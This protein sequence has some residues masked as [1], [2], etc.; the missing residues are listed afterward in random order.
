MNTSAGNFSI[1]V[2]GRKIAF[3]TLVQYAG[4]GL[5]LVLAAISLK[6]ISNFLSQGGYGVYASIT[7]YALFFSTIANLG[8]FGNVVRMMAEKPTDSGIFMN[9]LVL[10]MITALIFFVSGVAISFLNGMNS[11]FIIGTTL[12]LGSLFFDYVTSVCDGMLQANYEMGR[13]NF[14]LVLGKI[15]NTSAIFL[16]TRTF[17]GDID[18]VGMFCVLGIIMSGSFVTAAL[19]LFFVSR[20]IHLKF[21][22]NKTLMIKIL[23]VSVP[24]GVINIVNN[25]YFR[26]L[27]D[28]LSRGALDDVHFA[29]FNIYFRIAQVLSLASTFLMFSALPALTD[30]IKEGHKEKAQKLYRIMRKILL[31]GGAVLVILGS[32]L[33]PTVI[34]LLT[35]QKCNHPEH[36]PP[37]HLHIPFGKKYVHICPGCERRIELIPPN[38]S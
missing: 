2:L 27:P 32:L 17:H 16:L 5:Q 36:E 26:F 1:G 18:I 37:T 19:S 9:S 29:S 21:E 10:R 4:K 33:G 15:I 38:V 30:A 22:W 13:A 6:L 23:E 8:I 25:L 34:A 11:I 3:S 31:G 35:H 20:K 7:E 24:F 12:F 28:Y 14:A